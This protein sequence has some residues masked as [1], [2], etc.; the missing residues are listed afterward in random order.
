MTYIELE[1]DKMVHLLVQGYN[2]SFDMDT[3]SH[4]TWIMKSLSQ[5]LSH[6]ASGANTSNVLM[7]GSQEY[8]ILDVFLNFTLQHGTVILNQ[9][10]Y[11]PK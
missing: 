10:E 3:W 7:K 2:Q 6:D 5:F 9:I 11:N 8:G 1:F 4:V